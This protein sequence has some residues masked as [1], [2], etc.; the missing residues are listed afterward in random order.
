MIPEG[1][2]I[3]VKAADEEEHEYTVRV[4]NPPPAVIPE[5]K[6]EV[7]TEI[8]PKADVKADAVAAATDK[9]ETH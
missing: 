7:K 1:Q 4:R 3:E 8:T 6:T 5:S 9:V 2:E